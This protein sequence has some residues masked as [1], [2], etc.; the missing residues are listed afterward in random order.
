MLTNHHRPGLGVGDRNLIPGGEHI[1]CSQRGLRTVALK[2]MV[3]TQLLQ[4]S[5]LA[6]TSPKSSFVTEMNRM[7]WYSKSGKKMRCMV[8]GLVNKGGV[9]SLIGDFPRF[10]HLL[11]FA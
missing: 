3:M 4:E 5:R 8:K 10:K 6:E 9:D 2:G 7:P 1:H 11:R